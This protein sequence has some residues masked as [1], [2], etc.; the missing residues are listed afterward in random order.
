M[1]LKALR[2]NNK[3][4]D[5]NLLNMKELKLRH[6]DKFGESGQMDWK[7]FEKEIRPYN[8]I[9][10]RPDKNSLSF[11]IH[12][13]EKEDGEGFNGCTVD[14]LGEALVMILKAINGFISETHTTEAIKKFEEGLKLL[15][16]NKGV[17]LQRQIRNFC[18]ITSKY[19]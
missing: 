11:T 13:P 16:R 1:A 18:E 9:H 2:F 12:N 5:F 17:D 15:N 8:F 10:Y 19:E 7:F 3:I 6:P 4:G 14:C